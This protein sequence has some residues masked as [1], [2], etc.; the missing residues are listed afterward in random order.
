MLFINIV[1]CATDFYYLDVCSYSAYTQI[2]AAIC[3]Q[4]RSIKIL[5]QTYTSVRGNAHALSPTVLF[6]LRSAITNHCGECGLKKINKILWI[7]FSIAKKTQAQT[8]IF[9]PSWILCT[10]FFL[11]WCGRKENWFFY[12]IK[13]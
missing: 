9:N 6:Y 1:V 4:I 7:E 10:R 5:L 11:L 13:N 12:L 2:F 3:T 8:E